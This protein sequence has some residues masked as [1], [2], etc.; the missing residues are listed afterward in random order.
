MALDFAGLKSIISSWALPGGEPGFD[1][2]LPGFIQ[3]AEARF[4]REVRAHNMIGV[5]DMTTDEPFPE[6]PPDW[7]ET[8][9]VSYKGGAPLKQLTIN[10]QQL[11]FY[12]A[13]VPWGYCNTDG[14]LRLVPSPNAEQTFEIVYYRSLEALSDL[15]PV[16]W[17]LFMHPDCYIFA[18]LQ[19]AQDFLQ[20]TEESV[21][22]GALAGDMIAKV[23]ERSKE[24]EFSRAQTLTR[25]VSFG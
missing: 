22:Y 5:S 3:M 24:Q 20:N 6:M 21:K 15:V 4:N 10:Q 2:Q 18:S 25:T 11:A 7:L 9:Q 12:A 19:Y 8:I 16:N 23:N 13:G 17:M 14:G 1:L